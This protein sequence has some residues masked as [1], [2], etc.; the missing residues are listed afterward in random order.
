MKNRTEI[1]FDAL[2]SDWSKETCMYAAKFFD[3]VQCALLGR[4]RAKT[5]N[6]ARSRSYAIRY[7]FSEEFEE[8]CTLLNIEAGYVRRKVKEAL[9]NERVKRFISGGF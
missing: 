5:R 6:R 1:S 3:I 4:D 9:G 8:L 7:V 2:N